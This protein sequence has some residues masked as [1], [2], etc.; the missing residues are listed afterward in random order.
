MNDAFRISA[1]VGRIKRRAGK[2]LS[3]S[4][5]CLRAQP[6]QRHEF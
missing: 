2:I 5:I 4:F 3:A 6:A 1:G